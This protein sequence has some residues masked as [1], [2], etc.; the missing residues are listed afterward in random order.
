MQ[1]YKILLQGIGMNKGCHEAYVNTSGVCLVLMDTLCRASLASTPHCFLC[2]GMRHFNLIDT[3]DVS[4]VTSSP[5][6]IGWEECESVRN[7]TP[8]GNHPSFDMRCYRWREKTRRKIQVG[9]PRSASRLQDPE[10]PV[11][12]TR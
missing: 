8:A 1:A 12:G 11:C 7:G 5:N 10:V 2:V 6:F 9:C 4:S 3:D